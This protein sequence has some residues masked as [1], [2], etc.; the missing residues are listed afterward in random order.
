MFCL[1]VLQSVQR[2]RFLFEHRSHD[3]P[4][5]V[6]QSHAQGGSGTCPVCSIQL[7]SDGS[8]AAHVD[9][10]LEEQQRTVGV[11]QGSDSESSGS[12]TYEEYTWCNMTRI[13][14]TSMLSPK[15]RA[16]QW[17]ILAR[18]RDESSYLSLLIPF[19]ACSM[20]L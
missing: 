9:A 2:R 10:C 15:T 16:S 20:L 17:E 18:Q 3:Q 7:P 4:T 11:V 14:T 8:G 13:R 19:Q 1:K 12:E 6:P 5:S